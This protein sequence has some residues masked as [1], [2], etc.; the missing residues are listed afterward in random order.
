MLEEGRRGERRG[1]EVLGEERRGEHVEVEEEERVQ[2]RRRD[3][4]S[5]GERMET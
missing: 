3:G 4:T 1:E 2:R 5:L